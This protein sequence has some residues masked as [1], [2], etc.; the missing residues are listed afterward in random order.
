MNKITP[1]QYGI[2]CDIIERAWHHDV[3]EPEPGD[4]MFTS[5]YA[6]T[7]SMRIVEVLDLEFVDPRYEAEKANPTDRFGLPRPMH[8]GREQQEFNS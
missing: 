4:I 2:L 1:E 8:G 6:R 7:A 3:V 5:K